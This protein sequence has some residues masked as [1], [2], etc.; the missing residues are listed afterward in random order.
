M[1]NWGVEQQPFAT[2]GDATY[3]TLRGPEGQVRVGGKLAAV[4]ALIEALR[5]PEAPAEERRRVLRAVLADGKGAHAAMIFEFPDGHELT[6]ADVNQ[7]E[8]FT[9]DKLKCTMIALS[10]AWLPVPTAEQVE[11]MSGAEEAS[12]EPDAGLS[13]RTPV[14][15][16]AG[17]GRPN[18]RAVPALAGDSERPS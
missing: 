15:D 9:S 12:T 11:A 10:W 3:A 17:E 6:V 16:V 1:R 4:N 18:L 13:D 14:S 8:A 7:V 5:G 2:V